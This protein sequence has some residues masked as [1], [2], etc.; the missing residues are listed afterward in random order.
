MRAIVMSEL[1]AEP[2]FA[3]RFPIWCSDWWR[4][5]SEDIAKNNVPAVF[6]AAADLGGGYER[7]LSGKDHERLFSYYDLPFAERRR[8]DD[9]IHDGFGMLGRSRGGNAGRDRVYMEDCRDVHGS[10]S[11]VPRSERSVRDLLTDVL[12]EKSDV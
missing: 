9:G 2:P 4:N 1:N 6:E 11:A 10:V 8:I 5:T 3:W 7:L 12:L